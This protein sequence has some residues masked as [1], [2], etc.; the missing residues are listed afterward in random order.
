[1]KRTTYNFFYICDRC[2]KRDSWTHFD[3]HFRPRGWREVT[4]RG[5]CGDVPE[6]QFCPD[7]SAELFGRKGI[8][9]TMPEPE[10]EQDFDLKRI[11]LE[12]GTEVEYTRDGVRARVVVNDEEKPT[13]WCDGE[14]VR[15]DMINKYK[16][17]D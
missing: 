16:L 1:M 2:G 14:Q 4:G 3:K 11:T 7:C 17:G 8:A 9:V 13:T 15:L 12:D 10:P 6:K 5:K